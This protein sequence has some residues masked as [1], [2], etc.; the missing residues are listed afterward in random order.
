M[1]P[2]ESPADGAWVDK[3]RTWLDKKEAEDRREAARQEAAR[4]FYQAYYRRVVARA[5][6]LLPRSSCGTNGA[7][8]AAAS[9]CA[10]VWR[11]L[12]TETFRPNRVL[13]L[14]YIVTRRKVLN[15]I[16]ARPETEP[17]PADV[18]DTRLGPTE[19]ELDD[20]I[21]RAVAVLPDRLKP[22]AVLHLHGYT[23]TEI[24]AELGNICLRNV[25]YHL[26]DIERIWKE[27]LEA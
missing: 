22:V 27:R 8:G 11:G 18:P 16:R 5:R 4:L 12:E 2:S 23:P 20:L 13:A 1:T 17:L 24:V 15:L 10:R 3:L 7:E 6:A 14:L 19:S 9:A 21:D 25:H 26:D